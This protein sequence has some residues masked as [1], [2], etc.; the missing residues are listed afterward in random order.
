MIVF[1]RV[2]PYQ[3]IGDR[4]IE[5]IVVIIILIR[6]MDHGH[7]VPVRSVIGNTVYAVF[8]GLAPL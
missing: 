8:Q 2:P 1:K 7:R 5:I 6:Q 3:A 4:I